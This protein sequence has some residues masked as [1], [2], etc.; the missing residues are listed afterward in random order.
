MMQLEEGDEE[1]DEYEALVAPIRRAQ[2]KGGVAFMYTISAD[3]DKNLYYILDTDTSD[4]QC[5]IGE[6][7][8]YDYS[9]F[10]D[11]FAGKA[12]VQD[13]IETSNDGEL[14]S[15]YEPLYLDGKVVAFLGCD[16][17]ASEIQ[18][19][20]SKMSTIVIVVIVA[21]VF[22]AIILI[23]L[24]LSQVLHGLT[25]VNNKVNDIVHH[26]GDLTQVLDITSGDELEIMGN[27]VN[28]LLSYMRSIM[29]KIQNCSER[30]SEAS[31][32]MSTATGVSAKGVSNVSS[33]MAKM[34]ASLQQTSS[35]LS[36]INETVG[37]FVSQIDT[38]H[39]QAKG[40]NELTIE[41]RNRA[42]DIHTEA[43]REQ[44]DAQSRADELIAEVNDKVEKSKAVEEIKTL[45]EDIL[46]ISKK[47]NLLSLNAAIEAARAG[48]AGR[49]FAVV[50]DEISQLAA[51]SA[52]TAERIGLV[53]D[54]VIS[55][56][57]DLAETS[58]E[59]L[60]FMQERVIA[61]Y[62]K[63]R[64]TSED[65]ANDASKIHEL[66]DEFARTA[67]QL[68]KLAKDMQSAVNTV[69]S[70]LEKNSED[71]SHVGSTVSELADNVHSLEREAKQN[72]DIS[73]ELEGEVNRFKL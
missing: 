33:T 48:E 17:D 7:F 67:Q 39:T 16:Y 38:V 20:L 40:G 6:E 41:I 3:E 14:I 46:G 50:A 42:K 47:T 8:E 59:M 54:N 24:L 28:E 30:L 49:G 12:Y 43:E 22:V 44:L 64:L 68:S 36:Q 69:N 32:E 1:T 65:Y 9:E 57:A 70:T 53:S 58:G 34:S 4:N 61:G 18:E 10:S 26:E 25:V 29:L 62:D 66:M 35:S 63:L 37:N 45:T 51:N 56:V 19:K 72:G 23:G 71:I 13:Y 60:K 27:S 55:A 31:K 21:S 15:A 73:H 11:V 5:A 2:Q 52:A